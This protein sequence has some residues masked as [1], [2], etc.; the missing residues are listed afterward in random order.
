MK[1][2]AHTHIIYSK[3]RISDKNVESW[4]EKEKRKSRCR[5]TQ[6]QQIFSLL[7]DLPICKGKNLCYHIQSLDEIN[8]HKIT[9]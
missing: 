6:T 1:I 7:H 9:Q 4:F 2:R 3:L 5:H 8:L